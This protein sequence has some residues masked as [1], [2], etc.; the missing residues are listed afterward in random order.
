MTLYI[1]TVHA[2][3]TKGIHYADS[4]WVDKKHAEERSDQLRQELRRSGF[5]MSANGC[6][7]NMIGTWWAVKITTAMCLD[8]QLSEKP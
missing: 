1:V 5:E 7:L 8:G 3:C 4:I 6:D 2:G